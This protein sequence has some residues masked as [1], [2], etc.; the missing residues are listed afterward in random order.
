MGQAVS[1]GFSTDLA[2]LKGLA[3]FSAQRAKDVRDVRDKLDA[4]SSH[5]INEDLIDDQDL[6][7]TCKY[8]F[9]AWTSGLSLARTSE[10]TAIADSL[11][12]IGKKFTDSANNYRKNEVTW[13]H[14]FQG[15]GKN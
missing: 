2:G 1:G 9:T 12:E 11:D 13:D 6:R 7:D 3:D 15:L 10:L 4:E 14:N 5:L 8:F